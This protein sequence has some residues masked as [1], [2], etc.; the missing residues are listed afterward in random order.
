MDQREQAPSD[1]H[2]L[3]LGIAVQEVERLVL[4]STLPRMRRLL[5]PPLLLILHRLPPRVH[6]LNILIV[7]TLGLNHDSVAFLS[8]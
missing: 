1:V 5:E 7:L 3:S 6:P 4:H 8:I 2:F